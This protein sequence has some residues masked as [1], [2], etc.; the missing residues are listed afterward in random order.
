MARR[1]LLAAL[2][3]AAALAG[4]AGG[5]AQAP[6]APDEV[7][8]AAEQL[9]DSLE[10]EALQGG[11]LVRVKRIDRP[12]LFYTDPT[13][14]DDSGFLFAWGEKGRPL[15]VAEM[16]QKTKNRSVWDV[17]VTNTSGGILR[18]TRSGAPWW[19]ENNSDVAFKDIPSA[20]PAAPDPAL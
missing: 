16:Y 3:P 18:A 6:D 15:A 13:R 5:R 8:K 10:L 7:R 9:V 4:P 17:H 19:S 20:P 12:L 14:G 1:W 2:L 11:A